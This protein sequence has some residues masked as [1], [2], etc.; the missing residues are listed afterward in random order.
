MS[1]LYQSKSLSD[2]I[3]IT[4]DEITIATIHSGQKA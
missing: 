2:K 3:F 1:K 4:Y